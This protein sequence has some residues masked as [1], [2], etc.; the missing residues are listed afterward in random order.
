MRTK[1]IIALAVAAAFVIGI[2]TRAGISAYHQ[3]QDA[4]FTQSLTLVESDITL[5]E[6]HPGVAAD[7]I[8]KAREALEKAKQEQAA[9]HRV[10]H[11]AQLEVA[12]INLLSAQNGGSIPVEM[13]KSGLERYGL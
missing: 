6:S 10:S 3:H 8:V 9:G 11:Q 12:A 4:Q 7:V 1:T 5:A 13:L 2:G